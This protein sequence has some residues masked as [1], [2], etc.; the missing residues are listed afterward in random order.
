MKI[1]FYKHG[2][3]W[4]GHMELPGG[5]ESVCVEYGG[6]KVYVFQNKDMHTVG[7]NIFDKSK[8]LQKILSF[9]EPMIDTEE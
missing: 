9:N 3:G 4:H 8:P 2:L 1:S 7:V 6:K 5:T